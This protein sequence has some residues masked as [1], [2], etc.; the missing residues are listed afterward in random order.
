MPDAAARAGI[1][2]TAVRINR[3]GERLRSRVVLTPVVDE[4]VA[5]RAAGAGA[6]QV[7]SGEHARAGVDVRFGERADA[8]R[9]ELHQLTGKVLLRLRTEVGAAVEPHQHRWILGDRDQQI[10]EVAERVLPQQLELPLEPGRV[11][12]GL[13]R[14]CPRSL[15]RTEFA[16]DLRVGGGEMVVPEERHLLLQRT[17]AVD[18]AEEPALARMSDVGVWL[19]SARRG[20][21]GVPRS[22][23][24]IIHIVGKACV[25]EQV[26]DRVREP[27]EAET[28]VLRHILLRRAEPGSPEEMVEVLAHWGAGEMVSQIWPSY[29]PAHEIRKPDR[30]VAAGWRPRGVRAVSLYRLPAEAG[31]RRP[32][33][34]A[35]GEDR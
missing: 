16:G 9:E 33:C 19:K 21:P 6:R 13:G 23:D 7:P 25:V 4:R 15:D 31:V 8:H 28:L 17:A 14:K 29:T 10:P 18:Q 3:K 2:V 11:L 32:P 24:E 27:E 22:P 20:D 12:R 35:D 34:A 1:V 5:L 26:G 30:I